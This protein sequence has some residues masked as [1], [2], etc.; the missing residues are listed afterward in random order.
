MPTPSP[1]TPASAQQRWAG[2]RPAFLL[3]LLLAALAAGC[4]T[5]PP[6]APAPQSPPGGEAGAGEAPD[7]GRGA[8][9]P[10]TEGATL[11]LLKQSDRAAG[12]GDLESALAYAERAVRIEPRR[13]DLWTH[14]AALALAKGEP[15]TAIQYA[16]KALSLAA[17]RPDWQ[18]DAWLVIAD[19][20]EARGDPAAAERIRRRWRTARG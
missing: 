5:S 8:A 10:S 3:L 9:R 15:Q 11:A 13:A 14:L 1:A 20:E 7:D 19:A 6:P 12:H 18:R 16:N 4:A 2:P 17:G